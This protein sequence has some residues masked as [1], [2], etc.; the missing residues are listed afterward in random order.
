MTEP[1]VVSASDRWACAPQWATHLTTDR[2]GSRWWGSR[3]TWN[4]CLG[5]W[6]ADE[7]VMSADATTYPTIEERPAG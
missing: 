1:A 7:G 3:P 2:T 4:D 6:D 5:L